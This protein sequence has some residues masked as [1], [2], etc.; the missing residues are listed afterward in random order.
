MST[1][2]DFYAEIEKHLPNFSLLDCHKF[3]EI[4]IKSEEDCG[5]SVH[6]RIIHKTKAEIIVEFND[7]WNINFIFY[8]TMME[9]P[10]P[11]ISEATAF[12]EV[13]GYYRFGDELNKYCWSFKT[14]RLIRVLHPS[15]VPP[16][17]P[18]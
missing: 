7:V 12:D 10:E 11:F 18:S 8:G 13:L 6:C 1:V 3:Q 15:E 16:K 17:S 2:D 5:M 4:T 14:I 9:L